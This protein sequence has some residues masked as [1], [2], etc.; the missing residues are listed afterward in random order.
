M[1]HQKLW[2]CNSYLNQSTHRNVC[3]SQIKSHSHVY[4]INEHKW[5]SRII[6]LQESKCLCKRPSS[7][8]WSACLR[9]HTHPLNWGV[10]FFIK[11]GV[12]V[13]YFVFS[14][15]LSIIH[16][17]KDNTKNMTIMLCNYAFLDSGV[18]RRLRIRGWIFFLHISWWTSKPEAT[19]YQ[20]QSSIKVMF[21]WND[22]HISCCFTLLIEQFSFVKL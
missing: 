5:F 19:H 21:P 18:Y 7:V 20:L 12:G 13:W 4:A 22:T 15:H 9:H 10:H 1:R 14:S 17:S 11:Y 16:R 6:E 2:T 8:M 3:K